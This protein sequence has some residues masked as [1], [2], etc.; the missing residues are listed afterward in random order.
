MLA[1]VVQPQC[2]YD[3]L[4]GEIFEHRILGIKCLVHHKQ[5]SSFSEMQLEILSLTLNIRGLETRY[6]M[7]L[8]SEQIFKRQH[9][10]K[11]IGYTST[12]RTVSFVVWGSFN[13]FEKICTSLR[14]VQTSEQKPSVQNLLFFLIVTYSNKRC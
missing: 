6:R 10:C 11:F 8:I 12:E 3:I 7:K 1:R 9:I 14:Y 5:H 4:S 2:S 13:P